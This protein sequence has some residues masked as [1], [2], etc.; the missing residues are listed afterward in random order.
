MHDYN[1]LYPRSLLLCEQ[2]LAD[3]T[4]RA[5]ELDADDALQLAQE[6]LVWRRLS[7]L[8]V[9]DLASERKVHHLHPAAWR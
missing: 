3:R 9:R 5:A 4:R 2:G 6:L 7:V 8:N 1:L